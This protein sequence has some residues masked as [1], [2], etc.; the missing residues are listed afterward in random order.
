MGGSE[1]G[2]GYMRLFYRRFLKSIKIGEERR[3]NEVGRDHLGNQYFEI[4]ADPSRGRRNPRRWYEAG[5][6]FDHDHFDR[7]LPSEWFAWLHLRRMDPPTEEEIQRNLQMIKQKQ[8]YAAQKRLGD[9][10][11]VSGV[12][13]HVEGGQMPRSFEANNIHPRQQELMKK[14]ERIET[15]PET[16]YPIYPDLEQTPGAPSKYASEEDKEWFRRKRNMTDK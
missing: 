3:Y 11:G 16:S 4:P 8:E 12:G 9:Q 1:R 5:K 13:I 7:P 6:R 2:V 15:S 14:G 10:T